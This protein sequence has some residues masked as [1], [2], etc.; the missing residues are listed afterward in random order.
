MLDENHE[1]PIP[2][3][4]NKILKLL[5]LLIFWSFFYAL[6]YNPHKF[7]YKFIYGHFHLWYMYII[8]GLYLFLPILRL[9]VKNQ[10][11]KYVCYLILLCI[12]FLFLPNTLNSV[13]PPDKASKFFNMFGILGGGYFVY[14]L[15]GW[16][17]KNLSDKI[18]KYTKWL[19]L[20]MILSL[21]SIFCCTQFVHSNYYKAYDIFYDGVGLPVLLYSVPL[22]CILHNKIKNYSSK[23]HCKIKQFISKCAKLSFGVYLIHVIFIHLY[24]NIFNN[25]THDA[26]YIIFISALIIISSFIS[27]FLISKIKYLNQLIKI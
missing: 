7:L 19:T 4:R 18:T 12:I 2:K 8:I 5:F 20:I 24:I 3:L 22:F 21:V 23:I 14:F 17:F 16:V 9:F 10:N 13:F 1:L 25:M 27:A 15:F 6:I 26:I 11:R